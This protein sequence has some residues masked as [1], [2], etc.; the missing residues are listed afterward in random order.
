M[1]PW[2]SALLVCFVLGMSPAHAQQNPFSDSLK[3]LEGILGGAP[4]TRRDQRQPQQ[5][6]PGI[7]TSDAYHIQFALSFALEVT[8]SGTKTTWQNPSTGHHGVI[9]PS[10]TFNTS[11]GQVCRK[12]E[13]T[14]VIGS[15][16]TRYAGTA[17]RETSGAWNVRQETV[18]PPPSVARASTY[19]TPTV[20]PAPTSSKALTAEAQTLLTQLGYNPGPV[21]GLYGGKTRQAIEAFQRKEGFVPDGQISDSL[22]SNLRVA[23]SET[24]S[25]IVFTLDGIDW[26]SAVFPLLGARPGGA[27]ISYLE[28]RIE[29]VWQLPDGDV[30]SFPWTGRFA[31]TALAVEQAKGFITL[32]VRKAS[33]AQKPL[34]I[35][36]HSWGSVLAY[37]ALVELSKEGKIKQGD[38]DQLITMGSP[39][40]EENS[41]V[42]DFAR[43]RA[44]WI[45]AAPTGLTV[46]QWQ[47]FYTEH[48]CLG[49]GVPEAGVEHHNL[50]TSETKCLKAHNAY[51]KEDNLLK[52][53]DQYVKRGL[54]TREQIMAGRE[55]L[56]SP[57]PQVAAAPTIA[58]EQTLPGQQTVAPTQAALTT[59]E[60]SAATPACAVERSKHVPEAKA[61]GDYE[62][63]LELYKQA[64][65]AAAYKLWL[66]LANNGDARAQTMIGVLYKNAWGV[67]F[68]ARE[69]ERWHLMAAKQ[70]YP[71]GQYNLGDLY[72]GGWGVQDCNKGMAWLR[73]A[74]NQGHSKAQLLL[75]YIYDSGQ[76]SQWMCVPRNAVETYMWASLAATAS[77]REVAERAKGLI[78]YWQQRDI[79][80]A[81]IVQAKEQARV[82]Q[83]KIAQTQPTQAAAA[84]SSGQS[85]FYWAMTAYNSKDYTTAF[86]VL[87]PLANSGDACAQHM[88]G[89][90]Y[91]KGLGVSADEAKARDWY[92][93]AAAQGD[94]EA[95]QRLSVL[96]R[97]Q[98]AA[99]GRAAQEES[100]Q[101][102]LV[103]SAPPCLSGICIGSPISAVS[104][105]NWERLKINVF[106]LRDPSVLVGIT[107]QDTTT[108]RKLLRGTRWGDKPSIRKALQIISKVNVVCRA[109]DFGG[110]IKTPGK[111]TIEV[112]FSA[113]P[114]H[115]G[116]PQPFK[117]AKIERTYHYTPN[118]K[119]EWKK[120]LLERFPEAV[121]YGAFKPGSRKGWVIYTQGKRVANLWLLAPYMRP[122]GW[123]T[124]SD[125][126]LGRHPACPRSNIVIE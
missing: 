119:E 93:K 113:Q 52:F 117:V 114:N 111:N 38:V 88:L 12:Y 69:A 44:G 75:A 43:P 67:E 115:L 27:T 17:C 56:L 4:E 15:S 49:G 66:P 98:I 45:G 21:D 25:A 23:A 82:L 89:F 51:F 19:S 122:Q 106:S 87:K 121:A 63:G 24:L 16:V 64:N 81:Q 80:P 77:D 47:N 53:I 5:P 95:A 91:E 118:Q 7:Q 20:Q 36:G 35:V 97:R 50:P 124:V 40:F 6:S 72:V 101:S 46:R 79:T 33:N 73:K 84:P 90:F 70:G 78:K 42:R 120:K 116:E 86:N 102:A 61:S 83:Q 100:P 109:T 2:L 37:R 54:R 55:K 94:A 22:V 62:R 96:S 11:I 10:Q 123:S 26:L 125:A 30:I 39:L 57:A 112:R 3:G 108:L 92:Q 105:A 110:E 74:A 14:L 58:P 29:E 13:R 60:T 103:S 68:N 71:E 34:V 65:Y 41:D 32:L 8:S 31:D 28:P 76:T 18:V 48:D 107:K 85:D 9:I 126:D 59:E 99:T 104:N 1:V